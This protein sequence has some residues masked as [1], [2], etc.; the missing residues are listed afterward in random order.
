M[1][2]CCFYL[3]AIVVLV[4]TAWVTAGILGCLGMVL[5]DKVPLGGCADVISRAR[6]IMAELLAGILAL[7]IASRGPP[8][9]PD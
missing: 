6:E 8:P 4:Q 5:I 7:L 9:P 1:L 2:R 3:F